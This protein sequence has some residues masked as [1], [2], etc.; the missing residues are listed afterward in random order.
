[1]LDP[2]LNETTRDD[3]AVLRQGNTFG[4]VYR[5]LGTMPVPVYDAPSPH[6]RV[7]ARIQPG[8]LLVAFDDPTKLRQVSTADQTF[9]YIDRSVK[10]EALPNVIPNEVYDP[11]SRAAIEASLPQPG[12]PKAAANAVRDERAASGPGGLTGKQI[13]IASVFG[14]TLFGVFLLLLVKFA[15]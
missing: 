4:R 14:V 13:A 2:T 1:V 7:M 6:S 15:G 11:K 3:L 5:M 9:G 8:A 12:A 10:L